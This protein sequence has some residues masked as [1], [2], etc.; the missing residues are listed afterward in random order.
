MNSPY[1]NVRMNKRRSGAK[2]G[3]VLVAVLVLLSL[4]VTLFGLW[5][6][7]V[8]RERSRVAY[9]LV[10]AQTVR[11]AE[12][13]LQRAIA[14]R[15]A[16][17]KYQGETWSVPASDL[18]KTHAAEVRIQITPNDSDDKVRYEATAEFPAGAVHCAQIT[19]SVELPNPVPK[20]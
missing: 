16:D 8:L 7:G 20:E 12:A 2:R 5:A 1:P 3:F 17:A 9:Q 13:G 10:Q 19:K 18:D 15:A 6:R 11:L 14:R 4:C